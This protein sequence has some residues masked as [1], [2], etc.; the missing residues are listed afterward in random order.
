MRTCLTNLTPYDRVR[1]LC[2]HGSLLR[3]LSYT[4]AYKKVEFLLPTRMLSSELGRALLLCLARP[5][6]PCLPLA[7]WFQFNKPIGNLRFNSCLTADDRRHHVRPR[8]FLPLPTCHGS[9]RDQ[10]L[11]VVNLL[12]CNRELE[13]VEVM[14]LSTLDTTRWQ[15]RRMTLVSLYWLLTCLY[16]WVQL[17]GS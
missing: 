2:S 7:C 11:I 10:N 9:R 4:W 15:Q 5:A 8:L 16:W 1:I 3:L 14:C 12:R 6:L 17:Y 13:E